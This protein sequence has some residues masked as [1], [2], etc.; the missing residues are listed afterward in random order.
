MIFFFNNLIYFD[1]Y[2]LYYFEK[3]PDGPF[4]PTLYLKARSY[5]SKI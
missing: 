4:I 3:I 5:K 1:D 2:E